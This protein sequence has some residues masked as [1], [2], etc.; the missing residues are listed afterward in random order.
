MET[1]ISFTLM[2]LEIKE[3]I[4]W[5]NINQA[6]LE[7]NIQ[8][9]PEKYS[10]MNEHFFWFSQIPLVT[11]NFSIDKKLLFVCKLYNL[12]IKCQTNII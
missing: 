11:K 6:S 2:Q 1:D 10:I 7:K 8:G 5:L 3:S 12:G 9:V 4:N